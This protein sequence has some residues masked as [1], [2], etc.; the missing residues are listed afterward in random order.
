MMRWVLAFVRGLATNWIG[1]AGIVLTTASFA[2]FLLLEMLQ[3][4]GILDN[5]YLGLITYL[6]LP[7][8]F[9]LGLL[10]IP[11][12]WWIFRRHNKKSWSALLE[13]RFDPHWTAARL[14]GSRLFLIVGGL[15]LANLLFLG[16]GSARMLHFM[17]QSKFCGTACHSVMGPEW[18]TY[19]GSPHAHVKC[20]QCHVGEGAAAL[21]D[22]KING[23][24]QMISVTFDLYER[25]IPTP[26]RNLRPARETCEK[27]H[28]PDK[29][30]GDRIKVVTRYDDDSGSTAH[31]STLVLK[32]GS[33][34]GER[35]GE[36]HWHV[37]AGSE[38]R[39]ASIDDAREEMLWVE[40]RQPDGSLRRYRNRRLFGPEQGHAAERT[41]DCV[42]CH[43]RATHIYERPEDAVDSRMF[44]GEIDRSLPFIHRE[45]LQA[46]LPRYRSQA[47]AARR[48][49]QRLRVF[50]G[51]QL[52]D[53]TPE[54]KRGLDRTIATLQA[55]YA[56]NIHPTM[57]VRWGSYPDH[58]GHTDNG[59][60]FR[61]H[62]PDLIDDRGDAIASECTL[63]HSMLAY[64]SDQ[65][66]KFLEP[67]ASGERDAEMH[68]YLQHEFVGGKR[69]ESRA[70]ID[71]PR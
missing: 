35:R 46:I 48:I 24:W 21:V 22:S 26:V 18:A 45:A 41:V 11:V 25:P 31:Y 20:V 12:G 59:G 36:I 16:A 5:A 66:F 27:C 30:I 49:D 61:C 32:V 15:T 19:Q 23:L 38:V 17:D 9:V 60:C 4:V 10:L 71:Q 33:G 69:F 67:V 47:E 63:C 37:A 3:L 57:N 70:V 53:P 65:P 50:Y 6:S 1:T 52:P 8:L 56:R 2:L 39:Y 42:D 62:N 13:E 34:E 58:I 68:R 64:D 29:F 7:A 51:K 55:V 14:F 43:N 40:T 44:K 28:W 54:Q